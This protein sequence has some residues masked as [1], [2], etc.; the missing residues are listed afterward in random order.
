[1]KEELTPGEKAHP[2]AAEARIKRE[3]TRV[4]KMPPESEKFFGNKQEHLEK[5][6]RKLKAIKEYKKNRGTAKR[7]AEGHT[8]FSDYINVPKKKEKGTT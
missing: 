2:S 5:L 7:E 8:K 1:M 4:E 3:I 6:R